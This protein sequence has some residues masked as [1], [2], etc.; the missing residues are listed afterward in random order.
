[1]RANLGRYRPQSVRRG[2]SSDV[3]ATYFKYTA[4]RGASATWGVFVES[5][6]LR[7]CGANTG[8]T[9]ESAQ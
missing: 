1:M 8:P 5:D 6:A 9:T 2:V 3:A 7:R 4:L